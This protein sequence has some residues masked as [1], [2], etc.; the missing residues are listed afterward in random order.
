[1]TSSLIIYSS[2]DGHTKT[3]CERITNFSNH[4]NKVKIISL[5]KY[6]MQLSLVIVLT[7][8]IDPSESSYQI[9]SDTI[10]V[11]GLTN[12]AYNSVIPVG[13]VVATKI[14]NNTLSIKCPEGYSFLPESLG[15]KAYSLDSTTMSPEMTATVSGNGDFIEKITISNIDN[16]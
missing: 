16:S 6:V 10:N 2:T 12:A 4:G 5:C 13:G 8:C 7:G 1:M 15:G 9:Y 11:T 14:G 3:I